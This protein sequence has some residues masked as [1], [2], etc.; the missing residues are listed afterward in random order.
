MGS[1]EAVDPVRHQF[2]RH[3][4]ITVVRTVEI[5]ALRLRFCQAC[6]RSYTVGRM[7]CLCTRYG[8]GVANN[9]SV[10]RLST[11]G[12]VAAAYGP[13]GELAAAEGPALPAASARNWP[14][15][16]SMRSS[17]PSAATHSK[18]PARHCARTGSLSRSCAPRM[19]PM[20]G[21]KA[22]ARRISSS[23]SR[24]TGSTESPR[25][26]NAERSTCR[27]ARFSTSPI[28]EWE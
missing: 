7:I 24:A 22:C 28:A 19:R 4:R 17:T 16:P 10:G 20:S 5:K 27:S 15:G 25:W 6:I 26:P 18:A 9:I 23:T 11:P 3:T 1:Q 21:R 14:P 12:A 2:L 8:E 13:G